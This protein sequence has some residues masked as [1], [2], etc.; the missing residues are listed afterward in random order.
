MMLVALKGFVAY[1][2]CRIM[3]FV[4]NYDICRSEGLSQYQVKC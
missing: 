1:K 3:T 4:A 2:V